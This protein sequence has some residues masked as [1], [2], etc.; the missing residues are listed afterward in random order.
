MIIYF[1][2]TFASSFNMI[3]VVKKY[4]KEQN[5]EI[6]ILVSHP[7]QNSLTLHAADVKLIEPSYDSE[8]NA[9][10]YEN[11]VVDYKVNLIIP[12]ESSL[13]FF[14]ANE[15]K[16]IDLGAKLMISASVDL[17]N[18]LRSKT[19]TYQYFKEKDIDIAIPLYSN[20]NSLE[21]FVDICKEI[22]SIGSI[23]CFKPDVSQG[24]AGFRIVDNGVNSGNLIYGYPSHKASLEYY[25]RLFEAS[26]TFPNLIVTEYLSGEEVTLDTLSYN[27]ECICYFPRIKELNNRYVIDRPLFKPL[28]S[29]FIIKT[30]IQF[31][32]NIQLRYHNNIPYLLEVNPRY[33]GGSYLAEENGYTM[34]CAAIE[35]IMFNRKS[36]FPALRPINFK[37]IESYIQY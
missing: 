23:P 34:L 36:T 20:V 3:N 4:F 18:V 35:F 9:T 2:R 31:L 11:V 7:D 16:F 21:A 28:I 10:F 22:E 29:D 15:S 8:S 17:L 37:I 27:H 26:E 30:D 12:G 14:K 33:S 13:L 25:I 32:W 19:L 6:T 24:A 5:Q 1:P